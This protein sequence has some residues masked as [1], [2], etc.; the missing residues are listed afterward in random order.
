[1]YYLYT[2]R[3]IKFKISLSGFISSIRNMTEILEKQPL[4]DPIQI[5]MQQQQQLIGTENDARQKKKLLKELR[6]CSILLI[7]MI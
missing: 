2:L 3:S 4:D 1:M 5:N 6:L 7:K